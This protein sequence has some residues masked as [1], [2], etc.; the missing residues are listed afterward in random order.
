MSRQK[1][2]KVTGMTTV[3]K[4]V[5]YSFEDTAKFNWETKLQLVTC[6]ISIHYK[7]EKRNQRESQ[8]HNYLFSRIYE[9][10]LKTKCYHV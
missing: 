3:K 7:R 5:N 2:T 4:L 6:L 10:K 1:R 8:L 9:F